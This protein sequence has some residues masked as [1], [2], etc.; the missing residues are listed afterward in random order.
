[1]DVYH[2]KRK[3]MKK[4][5]CCLGISLMGIN[6]QVA[7]SDMKNCN[8]KKCECTQEKHCGCKTKA[9]AQNNRCCEACIEGEGCSCTSY[10]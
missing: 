9:S 3:N 1:M 8:C 4:L 6:S 7:A 5:L 2:S 10:K